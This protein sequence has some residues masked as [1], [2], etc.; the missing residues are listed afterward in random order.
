MNQ[1]YITLIASKSNGTD[2]TN[3]N[4]LKDLINKSSPDI[5]INCA[6][7]MGSIMELK[8]LLDQFMKI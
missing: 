5:V 1:N 6:A 4:E 8:I 7:H 3:I 2:F